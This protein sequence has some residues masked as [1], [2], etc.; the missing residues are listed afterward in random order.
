MSPES[1]F[2]RPGNTDVLPVAVTKSAGYRGSGQRQESLPSV[3]LPSGPDVA[4]VLSPVASLST[5]QRGFVVGVQCHTGRNTAPEAQFLPLPP[6]F[7][8]YEQAIIAVGQDLE[9]AA[10]EQRRQRRLVVNAKT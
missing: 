8:G 9:T 6:Q 2:L 1:V 7:A 10:G 5:P 4:V 3:R